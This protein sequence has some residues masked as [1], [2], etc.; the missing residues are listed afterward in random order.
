[1]TCPT[2]PT[3]PAPPA[4]LDDL[5][6]PFQIENQP[7]RGRIARLGPA[8]DEILTRH[9]YP[10][11]VSRLVGEAVTLAALLGSTLKTSGRIMSFSS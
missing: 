9:D 4:P 5:V 6:A 3:S 8:V 10:E 2:I 1:M 7:V 11:P